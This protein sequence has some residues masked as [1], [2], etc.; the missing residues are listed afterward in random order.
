MKKKN[1]SENL[2]VKPK[3]Y[4]HVGRL[5]S[6]SQ[7]KEYPLLN[8]YKKSDYKKDFRQGAS[9]VPRNLLFIDK[10][11]KKKTKNKGEEHNSI[12][13]IKPSKYIRSKKYGR[14][15]FQ[16]YEASKVER[17]YI[18]QVAKS[19][20]LLPFNYYRTYDVFLPLE[21]NGNL[22]KYVKNKKDTKYSIKTPN[23]KWA[24]KH[25][26]LLQNQYQ[27]HRKKSARIT[28]LKDRLNY[29]HAL[30][31]PLQFQELK[32]IYA[33][34]GSIVKA[35]IINGTQIL[36]DTSLYYYVPKSL[37]EAY[38]LMGYLNSSI[39][40]E[41]LKVVGSTGASGSL[42]NIHKHPFKFKFPDFA[43][44]NPTHLKLAKQSKNMEGLTNKIII[45]LIKKNKN[46]KEKPKSIQNRIYKNPQYQKERKKLDNLVIKLF[47]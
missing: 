21:K 32:I 16:A 40:T 43:P 26:Q 10:I 19:T 17:D 47:P 7:K 8:H 6:K 33:G 38:Y 20:G 14:W 27:K 15:G 18:F 37:K 34:I 29:G 45:N 12:I 44:E 42:R 11:K 36:I 13:S 5:I 9:I 39:L 41:H 23:K 1:T 24:R 30:T 2:E 35:A 4:I 46:L 25:Y 31:N 28:N 3:K 22:N